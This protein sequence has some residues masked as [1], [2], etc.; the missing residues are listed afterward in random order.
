[1]EIF[2]ILGTIAVSNSDAVRSIDEV[3]DLAGGAA[4]IIGNA[5]TAIGNAALA[6]GKM[7]ATGLAIAATA[8][9]GL[10]AQSVSAYADYEQLVGGVE[11]L[12]GAGGKSLAEYARTNGEKVNEIEEQYNDLMIAQELVLGHA[13]EA[14]KT[15]G[16]SANEYLETVTGFSAALIQSLDGDTQVAAEK[17]NQAI[18][19]MSDNANKMGT[20]ISSLQYAY[21]GFAK[22]N[23]TMLDNLKLGYGGTKEEMKRLLKDAEKIS[24]VKYDLSSYADIVD[25]I[26]VVQTE[27]GITGT[28]AK[29]ASETISGSVG[30]MKAS[31]TNLVAGLGD[32]N[33]DLTALIDTFIDSL[34]TAADNIIPRIEKIFDG[35]GVLIEQLVP[36][37]AEKLPGMLQSILPG[38]LTGAVMLLTSLVS[39]LPGLLQIVLDQMPFIMEEVGGALEEALPVLLSSAEQIFGQLFN[40]IFND[41]LGL[42]VNAGELFSE[43]NNAFLTISET[44]LPLVPVF[45]TLFTDLL[46]K[47]VPLAEDLLPIIA[48]LLIM[49]APIFAD[50]MASTVEMYILYAES[51]IPV[52]E[53]LCDFIKIYLLPLFD[54]MFTEWVDLGGIID[55][56]AVMLEGVVDIISGVFG[57]IYSVVEAW[58]ALFNGD[59]ETFALKML[60]ACVNTWK[61]LLGVL[62]LAWPAVIAWVEKIINWFVENWESIKEFFVNIGTWIA[63]AFV[64]GLE[65]LKNLLSGAWS[66]CVNAFNTAKSFV[67]GI[68]E[69]IYTTIKGKIESA[70]QFVKDGIDKLKSLFNFEWELPKLKMPHFKISGEFSLNP[71]SVPSFGVEWYK[72]GAVL[73]EPTA[74]GMHGNKLMVGGEAGPE[75]I[76]PIATLQKYVEDAVASQN[77][78][79]VEVLYKI[80]AAITSMDGNM[81]ENMREAL[82]GTSLELNRREFGRLVKAVN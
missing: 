69:S 43:L 80:L 3:T 72:K 58:I 51:F 24:G 34:L 12:F 20:D 26:H 17:A 66:W 15:A 7:I 38:L 13:K 25:A 18:I 61:A 54:M 14:Y 55:I 35:I 56:I 31:W 23:Y 41:L 62:K 73:H 46:T 78:D 1:M 30:A 39:A 67:S 42:D 33:A 81:G 71:P 65:V 74:F 11:T 40:Y 53:Q 47:L 4:D 63:D 75:A 70:V 10:T 2:R 8:I 59:I 57:S 16:M 9:A 77:A 32:D 60:E 5:F 79:L 76:A 27:M 21:Q 48:D 52:L 28:T 29:E 6:V 44:L 37:I 36:K 22:Q 64:A 45:Q 49:I 19:D 68:F 50:I 82:A